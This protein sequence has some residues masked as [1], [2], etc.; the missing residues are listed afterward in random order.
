MRYSPLAL[1]T[2]TALA[3]ADAKAQATE[4]PPQPVP[5]GDKTI[6]NP[7][8]APVAVVEAVAEPE[9]ATEKEIPAAIVAESRAAIAPEPAPEFDSNEIALTPQNEV[10]AEV[11]TPDRLCQA[12]TRDCPEPQPIPPVRV[13]DIDTE[14]ELSPALSLYIPVGFGADK[15]T[16]FASGTYQASVR[17]DPGSVATG[18]I[19]IGLGNADELAGLELSYAFETSDDFGDGAFNAKLHRRFGRDWAAAVGWNGFLNVSRNDFEHSLYGT[20]T[21]VVR[22]AEDIDTPFSRLAVTVG[23]GNNQ[24]RSNGSVDAGENNFNVFGNVAAR[25][26][27]PVS[28]I[29]EWTGQDLA[30]GAS[31]TP[32]RNIPIAITP[33]LRDIAGAGDGPRFTIG[34]GTAFRL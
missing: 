2:L 20:V 1:C 13:P 26:A 5:K 4:S 23:A 16:L 15:N 32:F 6:P 10:A 18:G 24:F 31:V 12:A 27:R 19:G 8:L 9:I 28:A 14:P 7:K 25:V 34:V 11:S 3:A 21:T 33:A 22:T 30:I 29:V 17:E